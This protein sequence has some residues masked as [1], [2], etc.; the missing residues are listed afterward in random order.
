VR[1]VRAVNGA[2]QRVVPL[3]MRDAARASFGSPIRM[4]PTTLR[5]TA[6]GVRNESGSNDVRADG[7]D[8]EWRVLRFDPSPPALCL[9]LR[10]EAR[11]AVSA[12]LPVLVSAR[13]VSGIAP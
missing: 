10:R 3:P 1:V 2:T 9:G 7:Q 6:S 5:A 8:V 13:A 11:T 4:A 12:G